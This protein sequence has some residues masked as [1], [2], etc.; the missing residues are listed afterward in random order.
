MNKVVP[1]FAAAGLV[2][3]GPE[4]AEDLFHAAVLLAIWVA[5]LLF[6]AAKS[7]RLTMRHPP[8]KRDGLLYRIAVAII[9]LVPALFL[10]G[11][12]IVRPLF[13]VVDFLR[14]R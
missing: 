8:Q 5:A 10:A 13:Y 11:P 2:E 12:W 9:F 7:F 1:F 6:V 3:A 4:L 14:G